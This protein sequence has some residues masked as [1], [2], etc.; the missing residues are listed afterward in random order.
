MKAVQQ[1][2]RCA[3][4]DMQR[5]VGQ[6]CRFMNSERYRTRA[7]NA[8][9]NEYVRRLRTPSMLRAPCFVTSYNQPVPAT[10]GLPLDP[11][12]PIPISA[13]DD[14]FHPVFYIAYYVIATVASPLDRPG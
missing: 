7:I 11:H 12:P 8:V 1:L 13:V 10:W 4:C 6:E 9:Y 2:R 3:L 5:E 14:D